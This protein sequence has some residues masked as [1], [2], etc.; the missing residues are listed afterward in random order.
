MLF[1]LNAKMHSIKLT[2]LLAESTFKALYAGFVENIEQLALKTPKCKPALELSVALKQG[3]PKIQ[4]LVIKALPLFEQV[5]NTKS[6]END[7]SEVLNAIRIQLEKIHLFPMEF[8]NKYQRQHLVLAML[9]I[10]NLSCNGKMALNKGQLAL[11]CRSFAYK[12]IHYRGEIG[13]LVS[14][15]KQLVVL[16]IV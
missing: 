14:N 7:S 12:L 15:I 10:E 6:S 8:F 4:D 5:S 9:L 13:F 11:L 2:N 1:Q 3:S 16:T